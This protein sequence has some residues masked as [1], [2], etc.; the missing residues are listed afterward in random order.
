ME[1]TENKKIASKLEEL[2]TLPKDYQPNLDS[3][4]AL[5]EA[6][7]SGKDKGKQRIVVWIRAAAALII[8]GLLG[9]W[10]QSE[11]QV[12]N[13]A[14]AKTN[15]VMESSVSKLQ[16]ARQFQNELNVAEKFTAK[17]APAKKIKSVE[18]N[19]HVNEPIKEVAA[20]PL[21][22]VIKDSVSSTVEVF[23]QIATVSEMPVK[24]K[25]SRYVQ[26]DFDGTIE[27]VPLN[28]TEQT[29]LVKNIK[30]SLL[31]SH[32]TRSINSTNPHEA[33]FKINF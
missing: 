16:P 1:A 24:K 20:L 4:W 23:T 11:Y 13:I 28:P 7:L 29:L 27:E 22:S 26:L 5:L 32:D 3:K 18:K 2:K 17:K 12:N 33:L 6:S 8:F 14:D 21:T 19:Q 10:M 15:E 25:K 30:I 31:K 9:F